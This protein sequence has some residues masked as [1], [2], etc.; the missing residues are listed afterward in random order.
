[1]IEIAVLGQG[2]STTPPIT[3]VY[4]DICH[5]MERHTAPA[6]FRRQR[7]PAFAVELPG[8]D[9]R[10][11]MEQ[12]EGVKAHFPFKAFID[13]TDQLPMLDGM[14]QQR[15]VSFHASRPMSDNSIF[16]CAP[17]G[18]TETGHGIG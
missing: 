10:A 4:R 8:H 2:Q 14:V 13:A 11:P 15:I 5:L 12:A 9:M 3:L 7:I 18:S 1:M 6:A 16:Q 17:S